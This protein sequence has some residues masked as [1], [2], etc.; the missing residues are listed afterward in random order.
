MN[1]SDVTELS[2][3]ARP[4]GRRR[5]VLVAALAAAGLAA[6]AGCAPAPAA[7]GTAPSATPTQAAATP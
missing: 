1:S 5:P 2:G 3:P 4:R 6:V 7:T